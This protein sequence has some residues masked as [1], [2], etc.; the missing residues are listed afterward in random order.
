MVRYGSQIKRVMPRKFLIWTHFLNL[1]ANGRYCLGL[2]A[3]FMSLINF[4]LIMKDTKYINTKAPTT[5]AP[6]LQFTYIFSS[7]STTISTSRA[8]AKMP[9]LYFASSSGRLILKTTKPHTTM[10]QTTMLPNHKFTYVLPNQSRATSTKKI[11]V[12]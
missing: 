6:S 1:W 3:R 5:M 12:K 4:L 7:H 2:A 9:S 11:T 8:P 10:V